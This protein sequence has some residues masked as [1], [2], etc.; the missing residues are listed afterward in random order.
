MKN[1]YLRAFII[2]SSYPVFLPFFYSVYQFHPSKFNFHYDIYTFLA[3]IGLGFFNVFSLFLS[4]SLNI[5][6]KM[7]FLLISL[8]APTIVLFLVTFLNIYNYN[9][10]EWFTHIFNLYLLYFFIF[11]IVVYYIDKNI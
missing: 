10:K 6:K 5:S 9:L 11:N 4:K 2:G 7:R 8:L 1:E 3:P